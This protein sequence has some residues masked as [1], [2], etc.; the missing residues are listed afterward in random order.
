MRISSFTFNMLL[1]L[2]LAA[3]LVIPGEAKQPQAAAVQA[4]PF[5]AEPAGQ[6]VFD[7][8]LD[9]HAAPEFSIDL[10]RSLRDVE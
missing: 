5:I 6:A 9:P 7:L 2:P 4:E 8:F 10:P 1:I 3:V